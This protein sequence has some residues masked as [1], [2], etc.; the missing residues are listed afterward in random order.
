MN[1]TDE[2]LSYY[3]TMDKSKYGIELWE[4]FKMEKAFHL[5]AGSK[6]E[7]RKCGTYS[8]VLP[9][10]AIDKYLETCGLDGNWIKK[11]NDM[12]EKKYKLKQL[13]NKN[14]I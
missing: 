7:R 12:S 2:R 1:K 3:G 9:I 11:A 4:D 8:D 14:T 5:S 10:K 13:C 6:Q